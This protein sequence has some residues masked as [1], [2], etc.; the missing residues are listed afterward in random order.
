MD[1]APARKLDQSIY[2]ILAVLNLDSTR[3]RHLPKY[4]RRSMG[5]TAVRKA[6]Q[7]IAATRT[8]GVP[9][10]AGTFI[11]VRPRLYSW[12]RRKPAMAINGR[13]NKPFGPGGSTRRL[14]PSPKRV[15]ELGFGGGET[16][17]TR[18]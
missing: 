2:C 17:S 9:A 15:L 13:R 18:A 16:G 4:S 6:G 3:P 1:L 14:H 8:T 5:G 11:V 7:A 12:C 10:P